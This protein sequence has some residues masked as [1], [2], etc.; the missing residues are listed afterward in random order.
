M[1]A[2]GMPVA[3][4]TTRLPGIIFERSDDRAVVT[5]DR[6]DAKNAIDRDMVASLHAV[7]AVLEEEPVPLVVTG[8]KKVFA[9]GA[10]IRQLRDRRA[11]H[12][13]AGIN[14]GLFSRIARLPQP[15]VAAMAGVALGGGAELAYAC[16]FRIATADVRLGNPEGQLGILAAA[17]ATWRLVE[18]VGEPVA[19]EL[20][21]AARTLDASE[22]LA[23]HLLNEVVEEPGDLMPAAHRWIDRIRRAAPLAIQ[24]TKLAMR[25]PR[26][27][28]PAF[29][30][31]AQAV[32]FE[33]DEKRRRMDAFLD[34]RRSRGTSTTRTPG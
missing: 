31:V 12:A 27:A 32:L 16:D 26:E 29:D 8:G 18:L 3:P 14:S 5:L 21:L 11:A 1:T 13:L 17:G 28:H 24:L 2:G 22:A 4:Q 9:A 10:D 33:T 19:K 6:P 25:T 23:L 20:L 15:T 30:D 7:C 34:G